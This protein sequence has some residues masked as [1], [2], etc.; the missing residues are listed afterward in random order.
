M[1]ANIIVADMV[2]SFRHK[3]SVILLGLFVTLGMG[4]SVVRANTMSIDM[5]MSDGMGTSHKSDCNDCINTKGLAKTMVCTAGCIASA[6]IL[7]SSADFTKAALTAVTSQRLYL[8]LYSRA[9]PPDPY[10]P[11]YSDLG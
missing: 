6:P 10:P 9:Y 7:L 11:R 5:A 2:H 3:I 1:K 8:P 4:L